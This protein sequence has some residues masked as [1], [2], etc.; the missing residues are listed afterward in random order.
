MRKLSTNYFFILL[1]FVLV[2][3]ANQKNL[4]SRPEQQNTPA[5]KVYE[6]IYSTI[7]DKEQIILLSNTKSIF[8]FNLKKKITLVPLELQNIKLQTKSSQDLCFQF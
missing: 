3:S 1:L 8:N 6:K 7:D 5:S 4:F 2:S